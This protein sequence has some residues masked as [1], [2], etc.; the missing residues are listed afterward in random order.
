MSWLSTDHVNVACEVDDA[1]L[2]P[3]FFHF[4]HLLPP[5][6]FNGVS[7]TVGHSLSLLATPTM[8]TRASP[9]DVDKFSIHRAYAVVPQWYVT[10]RCK[11]SQTENIVLVG[12]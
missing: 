7:M 4:L 11:F 3:Y 2:S 9:S 10:D 6:A 8:S 12:F 5:A 1:V